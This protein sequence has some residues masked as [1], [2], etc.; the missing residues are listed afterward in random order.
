MPIP[1]GPTCISASLQSES[2]PFSFTNIMVRR[3]INLDVPEGSGSDLCQRLGVVRVTAVFHMPPWGC[4]IV[5]HH[6]FIE[7][8]DVIIPFQKGWLRF[9]KLKNIFDV[10]FFKMSIFSSSLVS[11]SSG[12]YSSIVSRIW[13]WFFTICDLKKIF[14]VKFS[15]QFFRNFQSQFF[16]PLCLILAEILVLACPGGLPVVPS[17]QIMVKEAVF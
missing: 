16:P 3:V 4:S 6:Q 5:F 14:N 1:A 2:L 12:C 9:L 10:K 11:Y 15:G 13:L 17:H 8:V 7:S